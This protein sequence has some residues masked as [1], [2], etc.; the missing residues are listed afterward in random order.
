MANVLLTEECVRSCPYCFAK[1]YMAGSDAS[2]LSWDDLI[3]IADFHEISGNKAIALLGGEPTLHPH[4]TD[5]VLYLVERGFHVNVFTS[6]VMEERK[7]EDNF[8]YLAKIHPDQLSFVCNVNDP[9]R[10]PFSETEHVKRFL[11]TFSNHIALGFNVYRKDF[12]LGFIFSYINQFGLK[13]HLRLGLAHPIPGTK[14]KYL[15]PDEIRDFGKRLM[16]YVPV[17][18]RLDITLGFDCGFPLCIFSE[19]EI[20]RLFKVN[21]G[22]LRFSCGPAIDIGPDMDVWACFPLSNYHKKSIYDF[23]T[24][25]EIGKFYEKQHRAI[26][27]ESGGIYKECDGCK[28]LENGLCHGGCVAHLL[29][30]FIKEPRIR[31]DEVYYE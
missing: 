19:E 22:I 7:L 5:F 2:M 6:G 14:N 23:N 25:Q 24:L 17:L 18:D 29:S 12:D 3:Y 28:Y 31:A 9:V 1:K 20:G 15:K 11:N 8:K 13:R 16:E 10:S 27:T 4:F 26:R 30:E 21:K